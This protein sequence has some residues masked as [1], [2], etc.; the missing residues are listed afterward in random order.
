ME[1]CTQP[2]AS[3]VTRVAKD[4]RTC[5]QIRGKYWHE[6]MKSLYDMT[7]SYCQ[8]PV[9]SGSPFCFSKNGTASNERERERERERE[10]ESHGQRER[11]REK[12]MFYVYTISRRKEEKDLG[13]VTRLRVQCTFW[14]E[15]DCSYI[16]VRGRIRLCFRNAVGKVDARQRET[17]CRGREKK[18]DPFE[19]QRSPASTRCET[20]SKRVYRTAQRD[21]LFSRTVDQ[22]STPQRPERHAEVLSSSICLWSVTNRTG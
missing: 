21:T 2:R 9:S 15:R 18:R 6:T 8:K 4:T 5:V 10:K 1:R 12:K 14:K 22:R 19:I 16:R 13:K 7:P 17:A 20:P 11:E 3:F